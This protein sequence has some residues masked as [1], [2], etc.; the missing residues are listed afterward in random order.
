MG[1]GRGTQGRTH[2]DPRRPRSEGIRVELKIRRALLDELSCGEDFTPPSACD[3]V[4][5]G[6]KACATKGE[7]PKKARPDLAWV[8]RD[9][10][11]VLEID[12]FVHEAYD[13]SCEVSRADVVGFGGDFNSHKTCILIRFNPHNRHRQE[14]FEGKVISSLASLITR[15]ARSPLKELGI[16]SEEDRLKTLIFFVNYD[17]TS[18]H[19]K[20]AKEVERSTGQFK[21]NVLHIP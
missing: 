14:N 13:P 1:E 7:C 11:L 10:M 2:R 16:C 9:R 18:K 6:G 5:V 21:V 4:L 12:E 3:D 15:L 8:G 19:I 17:A 20:A